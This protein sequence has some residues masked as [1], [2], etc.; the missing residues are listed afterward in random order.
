MAEMGRPR[1]DRIS[2]ARRNRL[3]RSRF[4]VEGNLVFRLRFLGFHAGIPALI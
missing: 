1:S 4:Q 2:I 3:C